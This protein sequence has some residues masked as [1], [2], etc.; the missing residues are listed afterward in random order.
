MEVSDQLI[1]MMNALKPNPSFQILIMSKEFHLGRESIETSFALK[2][3]ID[4]AAIYAER[5]AWWIITQ[6]S[7]VAAEPPTKMKAPKRMG[8]RADDLVLPE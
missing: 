8:R 1:F 6:Q 3:I 7:Q 2:Q 4:A 5:C